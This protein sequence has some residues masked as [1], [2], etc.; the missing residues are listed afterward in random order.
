MTNPAPQNSLAPK[1]APNPADKTRK[2]LI[3]IIVLLVLIIAMFGV[4]LTLKVS[5]D[6]AGVA[7]EQGASST[8]GGGAAAGNGASEETVKKVVTVYKEVLA[9]PNP[10]VRSS[11]FSVAPLEI[12]AETSYALVDLN[13]DC[14]PEL[15]LNYGP[16]PPL[17]EISVV[18]IFGVD[19]AGQK[20]DFG[21]LYHDGVA[22]AGGARFSLQQADDGR[23][24]LYH[25]GSARDPHT[26]RITR[27]GSQISEAPDS[28]TGQQISW[29]PSGDTNP[30]DQLGTSPNCEGAGS[31][32]SGSGGQPL[33][34]GPNPTAGAGAS[35]RGGGA[36]AGSGANTVGNSMYD[37]QKPA[38]ESQRYV[39]QTVTGTVKIFQTQ[40]EVLAFE[41]R[42]NPNPGTSKG[43]FAVL[44]LDQPKE[45]TAYLAGG[46]RR[47]ET[48]TVKK[49]VVNPDNYTDGQRVTISFIP[50]ETQ[51][52]SSPDVPGGLRVEDIPYRG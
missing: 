32:S 38:D 48:R 16:Q 10:S 13:S 27:D 33:A 31:G 28:A 30:L 41:Q 25:Y 52:P 29:T 9:N 2:Q 21:K 22:G 40:E 44:I 49:V 36:G 34:D 18:G 14:V 45:V 26:M 46:E 3:A 42:A 51:W 15:L 1:S 17:H 8:S 6:R 4:I 35:G 24:L 23:G 12:G 7:A 43:P 19:D 20:V 50:D 11:E 5:R 37:T 47:L 39:T